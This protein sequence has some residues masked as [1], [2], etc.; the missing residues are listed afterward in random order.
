MVGLLHA[1]SSR[2]RGRNDV[3]SGIDGNRGSSGSISGRCRCRLAVDLI[4]ALVAFARDVASF[5]TAVA[6]LAGG[7]ER[8]SVR[9]SALARDMTKLPT[10]IALHG[11]GLTVASK[12]VRTTALVASSRTR[13][14]S[15]TAA[16]ATTRTRGTTTKTSSNTRSRAS[17]SKVTRHATGVAAS[18]STTVQ[19]EGRTV[20]L[21]MSKALAVVA[22]LS[23]GSARKRAV[24]GLMTGLLAV[25]TQ[26]LR[27]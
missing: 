1:Q 13:A 14:T 26:T 9:S 24:V 17:A 27:R 22:L 5:A 12:V 11:L 19:T 10:S 16:E 7:V 3:S 6:S 15:E 2:D 25:V 4:L 21:D 18:V 20:S 23:L 8:A